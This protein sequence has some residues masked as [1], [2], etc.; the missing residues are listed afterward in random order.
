MQNLYVVLGVSPNAT[1]EELK[2]AFRRCAR[3]AHP[4]AHGD[5]ARF[6]EIKEAYVTLGDAA[7]RALYDQERRAWMGQIGA[8]ECSSC[9]HA[10]RITRRPAEGQTVRCWYCKTPLQLSFN[11]I[12][13]AQRQSLVSETARLVDEVGVDLVSAPVRKSRR[14]PES[15]EERS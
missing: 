8:V 10:N 1:P 15:A 14:L 12:V 11:D 9:G 6:L 2:S 7:K 4:D 5:S 3:E 13:K